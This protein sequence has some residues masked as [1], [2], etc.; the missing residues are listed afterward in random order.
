MALSKMSGSS[1]RTNGKWRPR[2]R[3]GQTVRE[4][5]KKE[6]E[7]MVKMRRRKRKNTSINAE[8]NI[9]N[10]RHYTAIY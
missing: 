7:E 8:T 9:R 5:R 10:G 4:R 1:L 3:K 2:P 6:E